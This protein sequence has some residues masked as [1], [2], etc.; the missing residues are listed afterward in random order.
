MLCTVYRYFSGD[1]DRFSFSRDDKYMMVALIPKK[2]VCL[3]L[4]DPSMDEFTCE[5]NKL[6]CRK[7]NVCTLVSASYYLN[8]YS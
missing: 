8:I 1:I 6:P 5:V 7:N 2:V 4:L 3:K